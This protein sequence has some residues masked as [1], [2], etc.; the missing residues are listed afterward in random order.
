MKERPLRL[1]ATELL[2]PLRS[3]EG[4]AWIG[5]MRWVEKSFLSIFHHFAQL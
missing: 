5:G 3:A 1:K 4:L 2:D